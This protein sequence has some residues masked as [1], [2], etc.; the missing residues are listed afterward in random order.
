MKT[1]V[2]IAVFLFA[3]AG[4]NTVSLAQITITS[5]DA[6]A[7][8]AVGNVITNHYDSTTVS[9]DIGSPGATSWNFSALKSHISNTF[10]SVIPSSTPYYLSDFPTSNVVFRF[11]EI[12]NADSVDAW[13]Y[14][15]QN[16]GNYLMDGVESIAVIDTNTFIVKYV[17]SPAEVIFPFPLTFNNQWDGNY[18]VASTT[19]FNGSPFITTTINHTETAVVDAWGNLTMPGGAVIQALRVRKDDRYATPL[20]SNRIISYSFLTKYGTVVQVT[21]S[22]TTALNSGII[23]T[24]GATWISITGNVGIDNK[25]QFQAKYALRQNNPNPLKTN[26]SIRYS[27]GD[28]QFVQLKVYNYSGTEVATLVNEQKAAGSYEV[29][30]DVSKLAPGNYFYKLRAGNY[31][32]TKKMV[33]IR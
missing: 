27:I 20:V 21:A 19:Y 24:D 14:S 18:A 3:L 31:I 28:R 12:I 29:K 13:Q 9:V 15:T 25:D 10:T 2:H 22:D 11:T 5:A 17:Y 1:Q 30:F 7:I 8:N 4:L 16:S 23:Q 32:E 6:S 33:I 26:T